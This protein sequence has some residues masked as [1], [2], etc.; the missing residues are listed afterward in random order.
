MSEISRATQATGSGLIV[1]ADPDHL[2]LLGSHMPEEAV[3]S[4]QDYYHM[5]DHVRIECVRSPVGLVRGGQEVN[6]GKTHTEFHADWQKPFDLTDGL[7]VRVSAGPSPTSFAISGPKRD[8][9]FDNADRVTF[10]NALIRHLQQALRTQRHLAGDR[11]SSI[12]LS[13]FMDMLPHGVVVM[14]PSRQVLHVNSAAVDVLAS[15]DGL[16]LCGRSIEVAHVPTDHTLQVSISEALFGQRAGGTRGGNSFVV[17]R[18]SD[19]RPYIVHVIPMVMP[20][21]DFSGAQALI[22]IVDPEIQPEMPKSLLKRIFGLTNAEAEVALRAA[23][24]RGLSIIADELALSTAT[25]KTHL[26][27]VFEKTD[28]HRQAELARLLLTVDPLTRR[29]DS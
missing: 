20:F 11:Q 12:A 17:S 25:V 16:R 21:R 10:V 27:R 2:V 23:T 14:G 4:Y 19:K 29:H 1:G 26:Q 15:N 8:E 13:E 5:L 7:F 9:R 28:T 3:R 18:P 24:G 22:V 6:A